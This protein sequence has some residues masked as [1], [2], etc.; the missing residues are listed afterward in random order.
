MMFNRSVAAWGALYAWQ[1]A[2]AMG[3]FIFCGSAGAQIVPA[4][5]AEHWASG[6]RALLT[7]F[8]A[9]EAEDPVAVK[10]RYQYRKP[11]HAGLASLRLA[12]PIDYQTTTAPAPAA[13]PGEFYPVKNRHGRYYVWPSDISSMATLACLYIDFERRQGL[14]GFGPAC[15]IVSINATPTRGVLTTHADGTIFYTPKNQSIHDTIRFILGNGRDERVMV[16]VT[17]EV[18]SDIT[19]Y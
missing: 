3:V 19:E 9:M 8:E 7:A 5:Q 6:S 10:W 13:P 14:G 12:W 4:A 16:T 18:S 11:D 1:A 17:L 15:S 2:C